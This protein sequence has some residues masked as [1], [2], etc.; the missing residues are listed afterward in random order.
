MVLRKGIFKAVDAAIEELKGQSK[1]VNGR[2][3]IARVGAV[4]A[5]DESIGNLIADAMD[6]VADAATSGLA[7]YSRLADEAEAN[8][9]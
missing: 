8:I 4:S 9:Q 5:G 7:K 6:K 2:D 1:T 3:D